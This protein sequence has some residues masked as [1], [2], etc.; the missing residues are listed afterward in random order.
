ME[1]TVKKKNTKMYAIVAAVAV[2]LIVGA[3]YYL[4]VGSSSL[5]AAAGDNV[6][7]YYTGTFTNGTVFDSNI[8][9]QP[10]QF[11]IGAGQVIPGFD[12]AVIGMQINQ[13]KNVTLPVNE[14]YGPVNPSLIV[15]V[16]VNAIKIQNSTMTLG[17]IITRVV[18][19]QQIEG[20]VT[21]LNS[22]TATIN[23]N[24][25]LAGKVLVFSI[26]VVAIRKAG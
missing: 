21:A 15:T 3:A 4:L 26:R 7:V 5:V 11:T 23:F 22:T 18:N 20:V 1:E 17:S 14:A 8:G 13:T 2:V 9:K 10:L 19:G 24:S 25:P 16:P 12:Q 6:T